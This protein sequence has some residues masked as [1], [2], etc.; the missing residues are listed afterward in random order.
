MGYIRPLVQGDR[1]QHAGTRPVLAL[2]VGFSISATAIYGLLWLTGSAAQVTHMS[3][4]ARVAVVGIIALS[5]AAMDSGAGGLETLSWRRQAPRAAWTAFGPTR[6][7]L[8]WGFDTGL[9][10]TTYR[11]T[12]LTWVGFAAAL[13]HLTPWWAG[14]AYS[15]GY[16]LPTIAD[17]LRPTDPSASDL[18]SN[19]SRYAALAPPI[20]IGA[21]ALLILLGA[22]GV[23]TGVAAR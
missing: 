6:A 13:L 14:L 19:R 16:V 8:L 1:A 15:T 5:A 2:A 7:V 12:S 4:E 9:A 21:T 23:A 3:I 11:V 10:F 18:A 22:A 17:I 20:K